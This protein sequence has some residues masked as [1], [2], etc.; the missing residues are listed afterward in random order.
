MLLYSLSVQGVESSRQGRTTHWAFFSLTLSL[1]TKNN[2]NRNVMLKRERSHF[3]FKLFYFIIS[4]ALPR[5]AVGVYIHGQRCLFFSLLSCTFHFF[6][7]FQSRLS[8]SGVGE[9]TEILFNAATRHR[10]TERLKT[11]S[12]ARRGKKKMLKTKKR[13]RGKLLRLSLS[14]WGLSIFFYVLDLLL[15]WKEAS[16]LSAFD[17]YCHQTHTHTEEEREREWPGWR[18]IIMVESSQKRLCICRLYTFLSFFLS[19]FLFLYSFLCTSR[20]H[21]LSS[22]FTFLL[23]FHSSL[24]R[25]MWKER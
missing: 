21:P 20:V 17:F 12:F 1:T 4:Y 18:S 19:F 13:Q 25:Q 3:D 2:T 9:M 7:S 16:G 23:F 5:R 24:K 6:F 15:S 8:H 22:F 14:L 10:E 11:D